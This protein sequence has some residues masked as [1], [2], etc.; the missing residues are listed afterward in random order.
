MLPI[1]RSFC[2]VHGTQQQRLQKKRS[3][4]VLDTSRLKSATDLIP[5][6]GGSLEKMTKS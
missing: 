1:K 2:F 4:A 3:H 5:H 6:F